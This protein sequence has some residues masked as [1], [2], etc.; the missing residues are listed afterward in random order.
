MP[1][2]V[3]EGLDAKGKKIKESATRTAPRPSATC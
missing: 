1:V 3:F 2:F